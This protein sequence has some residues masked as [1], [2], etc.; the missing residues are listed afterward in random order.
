M[1]HEECLKNHTPPG[2]ARGAERRDGKYLRCLEKDGPTRR[3]A[4]DASNVFG[5][6]LRPEKWG[7]RYK[8]IE[9]GLSVSSSECAKTP[10]CSIA[11]HPNPERFTHVVELD[12]PALAAE[13]GVALTAV[14]DPIEPSDDPPA[15]A[16]PCHFNIMPV[17][18]SIDDLIAKLKIF[19]GDV[20]PPGP[21]SPKKPEGVKAAT[22][23]RDRF[24]VVFRLIRDVTTT[25]S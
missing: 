12:L 7:W 17:D 3:Y 11:F 24:E 25:A 23:A 5:Y 18:V 8:D 1:T 4:D 2:I 22:A 19:M 16:N 21:K 6:R 9:D 14:Y 13:L 10:G 20:F 15:K